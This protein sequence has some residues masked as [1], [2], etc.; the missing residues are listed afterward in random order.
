M[1]LQ[2]N[3]QEH[4][5]S[6]LLPSGLYRRLRNLTGILP[7]GSRARTNSQRSASLCDYRRWGLAPRPEDL[8]LSLWLFIIT[9]Y[10]SVFKIYLQPGNCGASL[11]MGICKG[12]NSYPI[13]QTMTQ[14]HIRIRPTR[15]SVGLT[16][17]IH[18]KMIISVLPHS[19]RSKA[20]CTQNVI[21]LLKSLY[22][23]F[24]NILCYVDKSAGY[25]YRRIADTQIYSRICLACMHLQS[26][27]YR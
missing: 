24:T 20:V 3:V 7:F 6:H 11:K 16:R 26:K 12:G 13:K 17:G 8:F 10:V 15:P 9:L 27:P 2:Q 1:H 22:S 25:S 19:S 18:C 14:G 23:T 5:F 21:C 4:P